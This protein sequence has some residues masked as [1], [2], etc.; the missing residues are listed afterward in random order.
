MV[1]QR[2]QVRV[3][4]VYEPADAA[5][6]VRVLVDRLWPRGLSKEKAQT[7][8]W[9]RDVAP[10]HEL[11]R[12]FGHDAARWDEFRQ[13]YAA[14]LAVVPESVASLVALTRGQP[15]T[16]LFSSRELVRNNAHAL[17]EILGYPQ[18]VRRQP[19]QVVRPR[20]RA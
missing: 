14:E 12:W 1:S 6:G 5:D 16:L 8:Y 11:R 17:R 19:R 10:S 15:V 2:V 3:K 20:G 9:F 18:R 4:R 13:R 7:D